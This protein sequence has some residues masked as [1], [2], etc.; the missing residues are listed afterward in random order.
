LA[1]DKE[2][3]KYLQS[4]EFSQDLSELLIHDQ[5]EFDI[6]K[7]WQ[8][9]MVKDSPLFKEFSI[10]WTS[11]SSVYQS[12]LTPLAFSEIPDEKLVADKFREILER[13]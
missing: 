8:T 11:L 7:G 12:E 2:C 6:P 13:I 3:A 10:L 5:Q 9:K 4:S 1:N